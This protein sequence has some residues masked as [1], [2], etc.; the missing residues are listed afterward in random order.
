MTS[1]DIQ[2]LIVENPKRNKNSKRETLNWYS[3]YAGFSSDFSHELINSSILKKESCI[4]DPWNGGGTTTR[5]ASLLGIRNQGYDLNPVMVIAAKAHNF[6]RG[7][8]NSVA[9]L[10]SDILN[11]SKKS[12]WAV[13]NDP[14]NQWLDQKS[15]DCIRRIEYNI[16]KLLIDDKNYL[17]LCSNNERVNSMSDIA[18]FFYVALFNTV[19]KLLSAFYGSNPTWIK[20]PKEDSQKLTI[21]K[22]D[23]RLIFKLELETMM[24]DVLRV[25]TIIP[26]E[27]STLELA[28]SEALP[29]ADCSSDLIL[30]SPPY[31]TRIDYA[32]ATMAE[33]AVL[34][35]TSEDFRALRGN[36]IGSSTI[37]SETPSAKTE[38]GN[39]C[40]T[41]LDK[42]A[43]HE[44]KASQTYYLKNH[45]QYFASVYKSA[46]EITRVMKPD[47]LCALVV[48][49]SYYKDV[50]N[51]LPA[52]FNE[53][54]SNLGLSLAL[55][56][57][58]VTKRNKAGI[59]PQVKKYRS[60]QEATESVLVLIK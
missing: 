59:N 39:I 16:Q 34:G 21:K 49:D 47:S 10:V 15:S 19:R 14:L 56:R 45:L 38:W 27:L 29:A 55:Q 1:R 2:N 43:T 41:F 8:L 58:F 30:T 51:D 40:N 23:I 31:C 9:P 35:I 22:A 4:L 17:P 44:S 50:H 48:Q 6:N 60:S 11:K 42:V 13:S 46:Q 24:Q 5:A 26:R 53:M 36:L 12:T 18:A 20:K 7:N 54:F 52:I 32:V 3:Y 28:S 33:L 57:N 25:G 37:W